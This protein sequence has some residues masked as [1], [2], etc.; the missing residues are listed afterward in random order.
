MRDLGSRT[1]RLLQ[2]NGES[3]FVC[4]GNLGLLLPNY[5]SGADGAGMGKKSL[6]DYLP[7]PWKVIEVNGHLFSTIDRTLP[8]A[9]WNSHLEA[10]KFDPGFRDT[11]LFKDDCVETV[12]ISKSVSDLIHRIRVPTVWNVFRTFGFDSHDA[13][14]A[15][16]AFNTGWSTSGCALPAARSVPR[17]S[18]GEKSRCFGS[19]HPKFQLDRNKLFDVLLID[20]EFRVIAIVDGVGIRFNRFVQQFALHAHEIQIYAVGGNIWS[21]FDHVVEGF[22]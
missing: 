8:T 19:S 6:P 1:T 5:V 20:L 21:D 3:A 22:V 10:L 12:C 9:C 14:N 18:T 15:S 4:L 7:G 2:E 13:R 11:V 16:I 17:G